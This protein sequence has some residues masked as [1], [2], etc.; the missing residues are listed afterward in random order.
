MRTT[1]SRPVGRVPNIRVFDAAVAALAVAAPAPPE[2]L[3]E[4]GAAAAP[5]ALRPRMSAEA[6]AQAVLKSPTQVLSA[7][8]AQAP[9]ACFARSSIPGQ[10]A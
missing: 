5:E 7:P 10:M 6:A 4:A 3:K 2:Y 8:D 1:G 9:P